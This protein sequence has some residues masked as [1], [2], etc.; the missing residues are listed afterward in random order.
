MFGRVTGL[1]VGLL[2]LVSGFG[3][4]EP[5][6]V[7]RYEHAIDFARLPLGQFDLYRPVVAT[8]IMMLGAVIAIAALQREPERKS[9]RPAITVLSGD[10]EPV[11]ATET[12][13][14]ETPE[15]EDPPVEPSH[16]PEPELAAH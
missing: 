1:I 9:S 15:Q 5:Q 11:Q 10:E 13:F 16:E 6:V 8:L 2:V 12:I 3:L 4:L 14:A 7:G